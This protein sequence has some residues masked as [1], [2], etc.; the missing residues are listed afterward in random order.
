MPK[1]EAA[2]KIDYVE[3]Y[4]KGEISQGRVAEELGV[5]LATVQQ[6]ISNYKSMGASAFTRSR[7]KG[8]SAAL[9][10]AVVED[11]LSG[12]GSQ[13]AICT[14]YGIRAKS[15]LQNWI[16]KYNG[17]EE[18]KT[19]GTGGQT[20]MINGRKTTFDER[21]DIVKY[22]IAHNRNYAQTAEKYEISYQQARNYTLKC[23]T[24]GIEGLQDRRGK[25]KPESEMSE[26]E[27]LR[28]ENK[29]LKAEKEKAEIE[30]SFLKKLHEI[31]RRED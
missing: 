30:A 19:S 3:K 9:K 12:L 6:W 22:C 13:Q 10:R 31:E 28:A 5:S 11:Y 8:Y 2:I 14:K 1:I 16:K 24:Q 27:R 20:I 26:L 29:L 25:R 21:I 15:K 7:N 18:L 4:I 17:R 23:E